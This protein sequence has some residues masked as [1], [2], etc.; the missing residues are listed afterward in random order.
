MH[1]EHED[2]VTAPPRGQAGGRTSR[3]AHGGW[4]LAVLGT[5]QL[6]VVLDN[7]IVN[8]A[9]PTVQRD[10]GFG[11]TARAWVVTAYALAFGSL[12][13]LGGRLSD[14]LGRRRALVT[15]LVGFAAA[16]GAGGLAPDIV[17]LLAARALQGV[18]AALLAPAALSLLTDTFPE[19]RERVR[20][21]GV[22]SALSGSG[23][24]VGLLVGGALTQL[25]GW[26]WCLFVNV[27]FAAVA[28]AGTVAVVP[29][30]TEHSPGRLDVRGAVLGSLGILAVVAG[31]SSVETAGASA[32]ATGVLLLTGVAVLGLFVRVENRASHPIL[33]LRV[34]ADRAR[35]AGFLAV[36]L[37]SLGMFTLSLFVAY[38]L[39]QTFGLSPLLAGVATLPLTVSIVTT[40]NVVPAI[41]LHRLG[42]RTLLVAGLLA[43]AGALGWLSRLDAGESYAA[44]VLG[45]LV[46][47]GLGMGTAI[48]T[49]LNLATTG[50]GPTDAGS[51]SGL[52]NA[53]Q[54][55]GGSLGIALFSSVAAT[56]SSAQA[57]GVG[58]DLH[59]FTIAFLVGGAMLAL[60]A[61]L[62]A[63]LVGDHRHSYTQLDH[64]TRPHH[65][66]LTTEGA[67]HVQPARHR[68]P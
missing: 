48:S 8:I 18:F 23:A 50:V 66:P 55:V 57:S 30:A 9:L 21:F 14:L 13:L 68:H 52:V 22:F 40:A 62:V 29:R 43:D 59:G 7:S 41:L 4:V 2:R 64:V 35:G 46:L 65:S 32:P 39:Q 34:V 42:A 27:V 33:P 28:L 61:G 3:V 51:A 17:V 15:G 45:P 47:F 36:A 53:A 5:A 58:G 54:Q 24:A 38:I 63:L 10:L 19:G 37:V 12:L 60:G 49:S 16:S 1:R 20:A 44:G 67:D 31:L 26:R 6:M 56:A 25:V 11:D